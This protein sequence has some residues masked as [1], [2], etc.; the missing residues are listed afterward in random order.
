MAHSATV[1]LRGA[2]TA[3]ATAAKGIAKAHLQ[4]GLMKLSSAFI[5][6]SAVARTHA[7]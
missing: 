1:L 4:D 3:V 5:K 2:A 6:Q 7:R